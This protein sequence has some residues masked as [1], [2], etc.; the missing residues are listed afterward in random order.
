MAGEKSE[1][2]LQNAEV[3]TGN[4]QAQTLNCAPAPRPGELCRVRRRLWLV[5]GAEAATD[6]A[7]KSTLVSLVSVEDDSLGEEIQ[8]IWEIEPG[9][10]PVEASAL[11]RATA[12]DSPD[13]FNAFL[14]ALRWGA[15]S[16]ADQRTLLAPYRSAIQIED[17][18]L[19]PVI[20]AVQ[21]PRANLLIADDVGLGKTI[22]TGLVIQEFLS[23]HRARSVLIVVPAT[24]QLKWRDEMREKFGL[25][26]KIVNTET[27]KDLRRRRGVHVNPWTHFPR[28]ITS[29]DF[30]KRERPTEMM[31]E[32]LPPGGIPRYPR[33]FDMLVVDEAHMCAP[34]GT[35]KYALDSSRTQVIREIAPHFEHRLFLTATPHNGYSESFSALLELIDNQR[36]AVGVTPDRKSLEAIMVRR[37]KAEL[38]LRP[39]G[40]VRFPKRV[41]HHLEVDYSVD[42]K[43]AH[44]NLKAYAAALKAAAA[45]ASAAGSTGPLVSDF[46]LKLLK[47]RLFSSP[48]AFLHT[49][50]KHQQTL[51][52][53]VRKLAAGK[54]YKYD[55]EE[56]ETEEEADEATQ[57]LLE[58]AAE[59]LQGIFNKVKP[60]LSSLG[61][62][63]KRYAG[64]PDSKAQALLDWLAA[65]I[66]PNG[67]FGARRVIIFT[68]YRDTQKW[69]H[70]L[71]TANQFAAD[72]RLELLYGGM[73]PDERERIKAAF[74]S[75][76]ES[77]Q[78]RI[79]LAT[80]TA[81]E[82]IDLQNHC[83]DLIHYEIPWN[84]N[85][86]EQR[87]GR[88]DRHG[89]RGVQANI[90]HFV[91]KGF[92]GNRPTP[93]QK[94]GSVEGDLE[95]LYRAALKLQNISRD[96][97]GKVAPVLASQVEQAM[98]GKTTSLD[99]AQVEKEADLIAK[100]LKFER[101]IEK[102]I[103]AIHARLLETKNSLHV[104]SVS[105]KAVADLAL[106]LAGQPPLRDAP[107]KGV[108]PSKD[109]ALKDCPVFWMPK[110]HDSWSRCLE[111][112]GHPHTLDIRPITFEHSVAAGRDDV[113]LIHL[114]HPLVQMS[115]RLLRAEVWSQRD[116]RALNRVAVF[117]STSVSKETTVA[118]AFA[119]LII[120]GG[121]GTRLHEEIISGGFEIDAKGA[122]RRI[123]TLTKVQEIIDSGST[124]DISKT[125]EKRVLSLQESVVDKL[126]ASLASRA[127]ERA[128]SL[129]ATMTARANEE[130]AAITKVLEELRI[131]IEKELKNERPAQLNLFEEEQ[132]NRNVAAL[133]QRLKRIPEEVARE[134]SQIMKRFK[135]I[136]TR[137]FPVAAAFYIPA[138]KG[139]ACH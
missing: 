25:E 46:I 40:S 77:T 79:L 15:S 107:L 51:T 127:K 11:P 48:A 87:N 126:L 80:D 82:G 57:T 1:G 65:N 54:D 13:T 83:S 78:V 8:V 72:G 42:E 129:E 45:E 22:E 113:V 96:L 100:Q 28:L 115:A 89:Q 14:N 68:E 12:F 102:Q 76:P 53:K 49:I 62:W 122:G 81:S 30:L 123:D 7:S 85:R 44:Q 74:Q 104:N 61:T 38:A 138:G 90:Y 99:L 16:L 33:T 103:E 134:T 41:L 36:F 34:S 58:S 66:R 131:S 56:F 91:A 136:S 105:V 118:V 75:K 43:E 23:R 64:R 109:N 9:A 73:D 130:E 21:M 27:L 6:I 18:Q 111:G 67:E 17:Y 137:L 93:Q 120:L 116:R 39:D 101:S 69:L 2:V 108:W 128:K 35:G 52:G 10:E 37:I 29:I 84:P 50:E 92:E 95:F 114:N 135:N 24:L 139:A 19:D 97:F 20:R 70:G 59:E 106:T 63:G 3:T 5:N 133:E 32:A 26:F 98:L 125:E 119:R 86:M 121:D 110:L 124:I 4:K 71:L 47:K 112:L 60:L 117:G 55:E 88:I 31:R 94:P 132:L